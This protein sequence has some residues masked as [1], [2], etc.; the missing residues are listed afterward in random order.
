MTKV[1]VDTNRS[2]PIT[3]TITSIKGY[4]NKLVIFQ[5][6]ASKY[7]WVRCYFNKRYYKE[8]TSTENKTQAI[9]YAIKFYEKTI[10]SSRNLIPKT[11]NVT[12]EN[13]ARQYLREIEEKIVSDSKQEERK[14]RQIK[15]EYN[16]LIKDIFPI[17]GQKIIRT[18]TYKDVNDYINT[19]S[20]RNLSASTKKHHIVLLRKI[21]KYA[22]REGVIELIPPTPTVKIQDNPRSWFSF[23][24]YGVLKRVTK[25][26]IKRGEIVRGHQITNEMRLLIT[27]N[28][29]TFLRISDIKLL[30]HK[31]IEIVEGVDTYLR[32]QPEVSKTKYNYPVTSMKFAVDIYKDL[33]KFHKDNGNHYSKND[34]L[35]FPNIKNRNF[36][37]DTM[38]RQ[39]EK[40]L[41][42]ADLKT[43]SDGQERTLY[44]LRHSSISFRLIKSDIDIVSL[45]RN[46]RT[47][48]DM[49]ER[50][51]SRFI[52]TEQTVRKLQTNRK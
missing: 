10:L 30:K 19:I 40:I 4:P 21:F 33:L 29:N 2:N 11:P 49:I 3:D 7:W 6:P 39:F 48:S 22:Q 26:L 47:S 52:S 35:F 51:Y 46:A 28:V 12:F 41:E 20:K 45:A 17:L 9:S 13:V 50:F 18:I 25:E 8:T 42:V 27:F 5:I 37:L 15:E 32:I 31:H 38:R 43:T 1:K 14:N 16:K 23:K 34:Y 36:A 44:S 24:Q